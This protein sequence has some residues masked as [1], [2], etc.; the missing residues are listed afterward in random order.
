MPSSPPRAP[1]Q[2]E[3][4]ALVRGLKERHP[5]AA[6]QFYDRY[7]PEVQRIL[8]RV[9]GVDRDLSDLLQEVFARALSQIDKLEHPE[10][11]RAWLSSVA[12]F[13]A[14]GHIRRRKRQRWLLFFAPE[15]V[16]DVR[17]S[18]PEHELQ[19]AVRA[20]YVVLERLPTEER[21]AFALRF[22]EQLELQE[23]ADACQVSLAT[24]KRRLAS[25]GERFTS[26]AGDVPELRA[27]LEERES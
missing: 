13:T 23:V 22:F 14:R 15:D 21:I 4:E 24:I 12:V 20:V 6:A 26:I 9:L 18:E 25:A 27:W 17:A 10:R 3:A 19:R 5:L 2:E 8:T 11:L 16:P 7:A 1:S